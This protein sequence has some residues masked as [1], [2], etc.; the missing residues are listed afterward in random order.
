MIYVRG[1]IKEL[2]SI[3]YVAPPKNRPIAP[4]F[5]LKSEDERRKLIDAGINVYD[6]SYMEKGEKVVNKDK[7]TETV[8][9]IRYIIDGL[10]PKNYNYAK[11]TDPDKCPDTVAKLS[12]RVFAIDDLNEKAKLLNSLLTELEKVEQEAL[13]NL[14]MHKTSMWLKY[15]KLGVHKEDAGEWVINTKKR[16]KATC[17]D[18]TLPSAKGLQIL[19]SGIDIIK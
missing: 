18:T 16:T 7:A 3:G 12:E 13:R 8:P 4:Q 19:L 6:G 14:W 11:L 9:E 2:T 1:A 5:A 10:D 17:Y 15:D